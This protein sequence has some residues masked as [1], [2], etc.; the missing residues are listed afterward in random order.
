MVELID[1]PMTCAHTGQL[2]LPQASSATVMEMDDDGRE[3][4]VETWTLHV[5]PLQREEELVEMAAWREYQPNPA[6]A[7][8]CPPVSSGADAPGEL[9][10]WGESLQQ[11]LASNEFDGLPP[12]STTCGAESPTNP[13]GIACV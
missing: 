7:V 2:V 9:I 8:N 5:A 11:I 12:R 13:R 1:V 10:C 4:E 3:V 6:D